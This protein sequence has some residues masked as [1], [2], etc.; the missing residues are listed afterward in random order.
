MSRRRDKQIEKRNAKN[1]SEKWWAMAGMP[2][3]DERVP[4][5]TATRA[6]S[7]AAAA[8]VTNAAAIQLPDGNDDDDDDL[9]WK[10]RYTE[11]GWL[12]ER[13]WS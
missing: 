7:H 9:R 10:W 11:F 13:E 12:Q 4:S 3:A 5:S 2:F 8:V 1:A 6:G